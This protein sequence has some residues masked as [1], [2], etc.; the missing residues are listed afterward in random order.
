[1]KHDWI[2][3]YETAM[4][5]FE[6]H[7]FILAKDC[8]DEVLKHPNALLEPEVMLYAA[9]IYYSAPQETNPLSEYYADENI[10]DIES[11]LNGKFKKVIDFA[12]AGLNIKKVKGFVKLE[13]LKYEIDAYYQQS[14]KLFQLILD[15]LEINSVDIKSMG[16]KCY[17]LVQKAKKCF[18][19]MNENER[20]IHDPEKISNL[21]QEILEKRLFTAMEWTEYKK[22]NGL[23]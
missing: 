17:E 7:E 18:D 2:I 3:V 6:S 13:L 22:I 12:K 23:L 16:L 21:K 4:Q 20:G 10:V 8:I 1:M 14:K 15:C 5:Y 11:I 9:G 19:K